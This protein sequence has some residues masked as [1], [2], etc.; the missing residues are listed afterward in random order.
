MKT[1][2]PKTSNAAAC[3]IPV[4]QDAYRTYEAAARRLRRKIANAPSATEL[5]QF[6][7]N[8]RNPDDIVSA[9]IDYR[10]DA[11]RRRRLVVQPSTALSLRNS[12]GRRLQSRALSD[13]DPMRN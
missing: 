10:R 1:D 11:E 13:V 5:I 2:H 12:S 7:L 8:E 9:Y 3:H 6:E 4:N